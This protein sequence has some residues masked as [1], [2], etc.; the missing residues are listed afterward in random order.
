MTVDVAVLTCPQCAAPLPAAADRCPWCG[1]TVA[2]RSGFA[3]L[4]A[5][6]VAREFAHADLETLRRTV[7]Q[8]PDDAAARY[9][10][11]VACLQHGLLDA[12][13]QAFRA[14]ADRMPQ[15]VP[16][17]IAIAA[18]LD[19][20]VRRGDT[21]KAAGAANRLA[22][23]FALAPD[24]AAVRVLAAGASRARGFERV[25]G[26]WRIA[27]RTDPSVVAGNA[28]AF[29]ADN[30][31][32]MIAAFARRRGDPD[33][34]ARLAARRRGTA[35]AVG[36]NTPIMTLPMPIVVRPPAMV[37]T[38][39]IVGGAIPVWLSHRWWI[40]VADKAVAAASTL[41]PDEEAVLAGTG[42]HDDAI[43]A[44][45]PLVAAAHRDEQFAGI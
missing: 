6:A 1:T 22:R 16:F 37:T 33:L 30:K 38:G 18:V 9:A 20:Q 36:L 3:R 35:P 13:A 34:H 43:D 14:A 45:E 12:A 29:I 31:D 40:A 15:H 23:A 26:H 7:G 10:L 11:G 17:Q 27:A 42:P 19:E 5:A 39:I 24:D 28:H 25:V 32:G 41:V 21:G 8:E 2:F 44:C 4:D